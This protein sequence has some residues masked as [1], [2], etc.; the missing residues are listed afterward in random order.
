MYISDT[1][2]ARILLRSTSRK[3]SHRCLRPDMS[4]AATWQRV[5]KY[6]LNSL[7]PAIKELRQVKETP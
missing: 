3:A 7:A 2:T 4:S 6:T 1:V 5:P